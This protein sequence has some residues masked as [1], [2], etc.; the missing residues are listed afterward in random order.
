M[1][2]QQTKLAWLITAIVILV[3]IIGFCFRTEAPKTKPAAK[4]AADK[5][6]VSAEESKAPPVAVEHKDNALAGI[7][8]SDVKALIRL[9]LTQWSQTKTEDEASRERLLEAMKSLL[10][11]ENAAELTKMLSEDE[12]SCPFGLLAYERWLQTTPLEAAQWISGR[13][14]ATDLQARL[15]AHQ[16]LT[17]EKAL[18]TYSESL[19]DTVWKQTFLGEASMIAVTNN[20]PQAV[21]LARQMKSGK[22]QTNA[23]ETVIYDW[24][25]RDLA[26]AIGSVNAITDPALHEKALVM[27]AKAI[28]M[29][30]PDLGAQWLSS[31]VKSDGALKETA[32]SIV[33]IWAQK[34]P[35]DAA[36]WLSHSTSVE[37]RADAVNA[38]ARAWIKTDP[39]AARAWITTLPEHERVESMLKEDQAERERPKE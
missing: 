21:A 13:A 12:L 24:A 2:N 9:R 25:T 26:G 39:A 30:D 37:V 5:A 38:L 27:T 31:A 35:D 15:V 17:D 28:A 14:G 11:N 22:E 7:P 32:Q 36:K 33:E 4:P 23:V 18:R 34:S 10:T 1:K 19:P 6:T 8:L 20:P 29:G 16:L 3:L